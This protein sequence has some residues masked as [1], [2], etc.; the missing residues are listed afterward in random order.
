MTLDKNADYSYAAERER[1]KQKK[2]HQTK[3]KIEAVCSRVW[4]AGAV[5]VVWWWFVFATKF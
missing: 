4:L 1:K 2:K 5:E 3:R